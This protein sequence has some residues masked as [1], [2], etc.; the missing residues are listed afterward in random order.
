MDL[1]GFVMEDARNARHVP[2]ELDID[3]PF[4]AQ[5]RVQDA[6]NFL[7]GDLRVAE[8]SRGDSELLEDFLLR[9]ELTDFVMEQGIF[10]ALFHSRRAADDDDWGFFCE[11]FS[12]RV[13]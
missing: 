10:L 4:E 7:K 6:I 5:S 2:G 9:V 12:S 13:G 3:W 8:H 1:S 11:G